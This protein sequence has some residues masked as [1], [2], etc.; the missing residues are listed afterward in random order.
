MNNQRFHF[1][2]SI[3][4]DNYAAYYE[5][6]A[7]N[8]QVVTLGGIKLRFPASVLRQFLTTSGI[9]GAFELEVDQN[10]KFVSIRRLS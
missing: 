10:N 9:Q 8:V 2:L 5:G 1:S 4:P 3:S 7:R 6:A